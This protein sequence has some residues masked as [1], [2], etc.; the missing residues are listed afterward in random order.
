MGGPGAQSSQFIADVPSGAWPTTP[1]VV[2]MGWVGASDR[3]LGKYA[4]VLADWGY[5]SVRSVVPTAYVLCGQAG[6]CDA[7]AQSMLDFMHDQG[8]VQGRP[9]VLYAFSNGG[10]AIVASMARICRSEDRYKSL[11]PRVAACIF[12]SAP[13]QGSPAMRHRVL[14]TIVPPG[15]S[16]TAWALRLHWQNLKDMMSSR[17]FQDDFWTEMLNLGSA[18]PHMPL[19][20]L[21][22]ADDPLTDAAKLDALLAQKRALGHD[23]TARRWASSPHVMHFKDHPE[24]YLARLSAF[25]QRVAPARGG[26]V[27]IVARL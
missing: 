10:A 8:L 19:L 21:Y 1:L 22:S 23:V 4:R 27:R 25:L 11:W 3:A 9:L 6:A 5:P 18:P 24:E 2:L 16:R 17:S 15:L 20:Y 12:D 26:T 13:A 7:W 14:N